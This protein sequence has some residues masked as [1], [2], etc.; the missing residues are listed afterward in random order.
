DWKW[1]HHC[2]GAWSEPRVLEVLRADM[3]RALQRS[4]AAAAA[5]DFLR[6]RDVVI[7]LRCF[8]FFNGAYPLAGFSF[9]KALPKSFAAAPDLRF[10]L[11]AASLGRPCTAVALALE[12]F[13]MKH[14]PQAEVVRKFDAAVAPAGVMAEDL[15]SV[16]GAKERAAEADFALQV[17]APVL[18]RSPS[19]FS[20]WAALAREEGQPVLSTSNPTAHSCCWRWT[21]A[22]F[23]RNWRWRK[24][25]PLLTL[26]VVQRRG[27]AFEEHERWV[28]WLETN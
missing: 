5:L 3:R 26:D 28:H 7:H 12:S 24:Q 6:P 27:F 21:E 16:D 9:Y 10:L 23:G 25:V 18:F 15:S 1:P 2:L 4:G 14:Y 8:P 19:S 22:N 11:V 17:F 20:L 13:L